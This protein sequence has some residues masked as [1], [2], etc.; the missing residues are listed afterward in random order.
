M[1]RHLWKGRFTVRSRVEETKR[2]ERE[3]QEREWAAYEAARNA[4]GKSCS[5]THVDPPQYPP[6]PKALGDS[7]W[8]RTGG[9]SG[10]R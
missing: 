3:R 2:A 7:E 10:K 5:T 6:R 4:P 8:I 9:W 1:M